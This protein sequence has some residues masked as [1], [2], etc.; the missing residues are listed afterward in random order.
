MNPRCA[1]SKVCLFLNGSASS[2][3]A[4]VALVASAAYL[5]DVL[6]RRLGER[7]WG[8]VKSIVRI[9]CFTGVPC[10]SGKF[11][12]LTLGTARPPS[13]A[14]L[15]TGLVGDALKMPASREP[16]GIIRPSE[17]G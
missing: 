7:R 9:Q 4:L 3:A 17:S 16:A 10:L 6:R 2:T 8:E 13:A 14:P 11:R 12:F 5:E 1:P 15:R